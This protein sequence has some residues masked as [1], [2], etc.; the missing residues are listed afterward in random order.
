MK[1]WVCGVLRLIPAVFHLAAATWGSVFCFNFA[2]FIGKNPDFETLCLAV[3]ACDN[4]R[5]L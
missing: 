1:K 3:V 4:V 2:D 5:L